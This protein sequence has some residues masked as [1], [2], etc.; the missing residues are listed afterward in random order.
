MYK[1]VRFNIMLR[2]RKHTATTSSQSGNCSVTKK[3]RITLSHKLKT[4]HN[5]F[6]FAT[7]LAFPLFFLFF[8]F[9]LF[10]LF[11]TFH[12]LFFLPLLLSLRLNL[13]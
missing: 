7:A 8:L 2:P 6:L 12:L 5:R 10:F 13:L 1:M 3:K 11:F 4:T 9:L